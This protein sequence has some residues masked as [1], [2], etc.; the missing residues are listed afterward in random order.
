MKYKVQEMMIEN[1]AKE[2]AIDKWTAELDEK[3]EKMEQPITDIEEAIKNCERRESIEEKNQEEQRFERKIR[4]EKQIEEMRQEF[5]KSSR[6]RRVDNN[7]DAKCELPKLVISEFNGT[8]IDYFRFWNQFETRI[9]KSEQSS[10]TKLSY[11]KKM[12]IPKVRLLIDGL[13]RTTEGYERE[14]KYIVIKIWKTK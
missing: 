13:P 1:S 10:V 9:D 5:Q 3:L 12:V 8:H 6:I 2:E 14:K 11:R 7:K 4:E